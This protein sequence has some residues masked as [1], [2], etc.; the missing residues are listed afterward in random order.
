MIIQ[1]RMGIDDRKNVSELLLWSFRM[2]RSAMKNPVL[3]IEIA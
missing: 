1:L 3:I 2:E